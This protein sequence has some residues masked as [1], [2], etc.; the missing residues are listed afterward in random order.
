MHPIKS[1]CLSHT[2]THSA[3]QVEESVADFD[4][5]WEQAPQLRPQLWQRG[6]SL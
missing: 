4:A 6:L 5:V 3:N 1:I 2:R